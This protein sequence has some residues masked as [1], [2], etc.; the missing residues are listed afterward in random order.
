MAI[1]IHNC[2]K[3]LEYSSLT[4]MLETVAQENRVGRYTTKPIRFSEVEAKL[5]TDQALL[6]MSLFGRPNSS[7]QSVVAFVDIV[8]EL[9]EGEPVQI[10]ELDFKGQL[11]RPLNFVLG[12]NGFLNK[13]L[14][15]SDI[16]SCFFRFTP[17]SRR[18]KSQLREGEK[19]YVDLDIEIEL[20][21]NITTPTPPGQKLKMDQIKI[22]TAIVEFDGKHHLNDERVRID[23]DRDSMVQ[24]Q[25]AA[26]FRI[27]TPYEH[28][29]HSMLEKAIRIITKKQTQDIKEYFRNTLYTNIQAARLIHLAEV[30]K[31]K[32][33][34]AAEITQDIIA[35]VNLDR[36]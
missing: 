17:E 18:Q 20:Y 16:L 13:D 4:T 25:G 35:T 14:L 29:S 19:G 6:V 22:A 3:E 7:K 15:A 33:R 10:V 9:A 11:C 21:L 12:S 32:Q 26:V 36:A 2:P 30:A 8:H 23:K 28:G 27:Q 31:S 1:L 34:S 5:G 24:S